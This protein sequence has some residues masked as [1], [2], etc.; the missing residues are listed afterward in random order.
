L[1]PID[2]AIQRGRFVA[3]IGR[4]GSGKTTWFKTLLGETP[5]LGGS[6]ERAA[7]LNHI[8]YVPQSIAFDALLPVRVWDVVM[9][10]RLHCNN[11]LSP[12]ASK[13]DGEQCVRALEEAGAAD[14]AKTTFRDLSRGQRQ[15]V[16]FAR[17]LATEAELAMLDE[18]TAAMDVVAEAEAFE[19]LADMAAA[20]HMAILCVSHTMRVAE[21]HADDILLF[22]RSAKEVVFGPRDEVL[23][24]EAYRRLVR[25]ER[26]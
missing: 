24:S 21:R 19:R 2:L 1:P 16:M 3:V 22:D 25:G 26:A 15:R 14:L 10:G 17:M 6:I 20:H 13:H 23:G 8:A 11:F 4:N 18:P 7:R 9:Q 5:P 12:F